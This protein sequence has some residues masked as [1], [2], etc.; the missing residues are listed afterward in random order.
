MQRTWRLGALGL[1]GIYLFGQ[2]LRADRPQ[3]PA[4]AASKASASARPAL[5]PMEVA[6]HAGGAFRDVAIAPDGRL[7][8]WVER[9][10]GPDGR[11]SGKSTLRTQA[12]DAAAPASPRTID[13]PGDGASSLA[14]S[15]DGKKLAFLADDGRSPQEQVWLADLAPAASAGRKGS[16]SA[17]R[18]LTSFGGQLADLRWLPDGSGL[19][20]LAIERRMDA[21]GPLAAHPR[22]AG[23]VGAHP[24]VQRIARFDAS[25]GALRWASP[26]DL[27][28]YEYDASPDGASFVA[29]TAHGEGD[30]KW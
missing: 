19:T 4:A 1:L 7:V 21:A 5:D 29:T 20:A 25:D 13:L 8:A 9:I 30:A 10:P 6:L 2:P 23:F 27:F 15:P 12:L 16:P 22:D 28:V 26:A 3:S 14:F 24:D 17:L 11:P 18:R